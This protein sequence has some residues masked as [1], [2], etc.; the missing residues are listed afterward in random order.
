MTNDDGS[1]VYVRTCREYDEAIKA[2]FFAYSTFDIKMATFFEHQCRLLTAFQVAKQPQ[3]SFISE[4]RVGIVDLELMPF[5]LF[6]HI[7]ETEPT[8]NPMQTYQTKVQ[9]ER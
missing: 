1:H 5:S 8:E 4:P 9:M 6:P 3:V 2:E 7:G